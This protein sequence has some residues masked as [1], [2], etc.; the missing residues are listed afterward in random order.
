VEQSE[1]V[2]ATGGATSE[3]STQTRNAEGL[4][5]E[6]SKTQMDHARWRSD[7]ILDWAATVWGACLNWTWH[8]EGSSFGAECSKTQMPQRT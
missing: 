7:R 1:Q 6:R 4:G 3:C 5:A 8:A 2:S